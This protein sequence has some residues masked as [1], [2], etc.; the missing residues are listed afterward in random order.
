MDTEYCEDK[1]EVFDFIHDNNIVDVDVV[2]ETEHELYVKRSRYDRE[3]HMGQETVYKIYDQFRR[4]VRRCN[5]T[6]CGKASFN[7][8]SELPIALLKYCTQAVLAFA[9]ERVYR[10]VVVAERLPPV[11]MNVDASCKNVKITKMLRILE[12]E[13]MTE[14]PFIITISVDESE[15]VNLKFEFENKGPLQLPPG[16][17]HDFNT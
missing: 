1:F 17:T 6:M 7:I 15:Y 14:I 3:V 9:L 5:F 10:E 12:T 16:M 4:D 2:P 13:S 11:S 8:P